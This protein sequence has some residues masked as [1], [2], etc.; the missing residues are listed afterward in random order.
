MACQQPHPLTLLW[1]AIRK[2]GVNGVWFYLAISCSQSVWAG[3]SRAGCFFHWIH[4]ALTQ[5]EERCLISAMMRPARYPLS[6]EPALQGASH[7]QPESQP[8]Q[9]RPNFALARR[10]QRHLATGQRTTTEALQAQRTISVPWPNCYIA[11][12]GDSQAP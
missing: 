4:C 5:T 2:N 9:Y 3:S 6:N 11:L 12:E 7:D 1:M 8:A 10:L